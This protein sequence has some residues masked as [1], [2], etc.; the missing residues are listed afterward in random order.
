MIF[1]ILSV[2]LYSL[3]NLLWK[4]NLDRFD[5][6]HV[7]FTR[8]VFTTLLG[9][10]VVLI[11]TPEILST[12]TGM[13]FLR[14]SIASLLGG[15][16]LLFMLK[17]LKIGSL[18]QLG[19]FNM[20]GVF[21]S[22]TY[23]ILFEHFTLNHYWVGS[24]LV[25]LGSVYYVSQLNRIQTVDHSPK[26]YLYFILM[27]LFFT[28]STLLHWYNFLQDTPVL[29]SLVNQEIIVLCIALIAI[30][31]NRR[32]TAI[33]FINTI[34][35]MFKPVFVMAVIILLALWTGF[36]GLLITNP[37]FSAIF[38]LSTPILTVA[39][40]AI[41]LKEKWTSQIVY[42]LIAILTGTFILVM[43]MHKMG[44]RL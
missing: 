21:L 42:A 15:L 23:L 30:L 31:S 34:Q 22:A 10:S 17:S 2:F 12:I 26:A 28:T 7:M 43:N 16:G 9:S 38:S 5:S 18:R 1:L 29:F 3:N 35:S 11:W 25:I 24:L 39:L 19:I 13:M 37:F 32:K 33:P 20:L 44:F 14:S 41:F 27:T 36:H 4:K 40:G 6:W 8:A